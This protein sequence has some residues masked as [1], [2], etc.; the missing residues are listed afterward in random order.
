[1]EENQIK[2]QITLG[3][4]IWIFAFFSM[5]ILGFIFNGLI[6]PLLQKLYWIMI[7]SMGLLILIIGVMVRNMKGEV[8]FNRWIIGSL[9]S[10]DMTLNNMISI[11]VTG[12]LFA[13]GYEGMI[14]AFIYG[15]YFYFVL[16]IVCGILYFII[17]AI[18]GKNNK[19]FQGYI[20]GSLFLCTPG[21]VLG[22]VFGGILGLLSIINPLIAFVS[23]STYKVITYSKNQLIKVMV[24]YPSILASFVIF[25]LYFNFRASG[26]FLYN[27]L[28]I[29]YL[30]SGIMIGITII[31]AVRFKLLSR[32]KST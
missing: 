3:I 16:C 8:I 1:M 13:F 17:G 5:V 29:I 22:Y 32:E 23:G 19:V 30:I 25:Y 28:P 15:F 20:W 24:I 12:S 2:N 4:L 27:F 6:P 31:A 11:F 14:F 26:Y 18:I 10:T 9:S 7:V 21:Y